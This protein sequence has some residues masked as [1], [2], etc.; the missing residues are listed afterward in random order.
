MHGLAFTAVLLMDAQKRF[1]QQLASSGANVVQARAKN[2]ECRDR[3]EMSERNSLAAGGEKHQKAQAPKP[4]FRLRLA[5]PSKR[6]HYNHCPV[7]GKEPHIDLSLC[8]SSA[9]RI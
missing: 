9:S 3:V 2:N 5:S 8:D 4:S 1:N 7:Q 6:K